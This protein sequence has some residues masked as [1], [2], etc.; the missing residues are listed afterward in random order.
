MNPLWELLEATCE[1]QPEAC[2]IREGGASRWTYAEARRRAL[3]LA[4]RLGE[5]GAVRD[6]RIALLA[7]NRAEVLVASFAAARLGA[8]LVP[9][10]PRLAGPELAAILELAECQVLLAD[11]AHLAA[12][13]ALADPSP[14]PS[15]GRAVL[16]L[17][18]ECGKGPADEPPP[19]GDLPLDAPAQ[20][21]FTS[22]TTGQPKGV[23]LTHGNIRSH[24]LAA[25]EALGLTASDTWGHFAPM[26]HLADAWATFAVTA[27]G[28]AHA[29]LPR[30]ETSACLELCSREGVTLTNLVPTMLQRVL[31]AVED[32]AAP[33][34]SLRLCLSGGAPIA[35]AVV[36]RI[37]TNLGCAYRQTYGLTETSP[38]LTLSGL[39]AEE[40]RLPL[41]QRAL[42][43]ARTGSP[44]PTVELRVVDERDQPV[45]TDD[46]TVGEIVVRGPTVSPGYW[47][48]S[49]ATA[50]S[51][52]DGWF[53][54]GD[55]ATV[56]A[57]GSVLIVDRLKDLILSGG[58]NVYSIEVEAVLLAHAGV[59][60]C[61]V[62]ALPHPDLGE[63]VAAAVV[64]RAGRALKRPALEEHC[65][66]RIAG[67]KLPRRLWLLAELPRTGSGKIRKAALRERAALGELGPEA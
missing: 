59:L 20:L 16:A 11:G 14:S 8:L 15:G 64:P 3:A 67:Y 29:F 32:G 6:S 46:R 26:F 27:V 51:R 13:R 40:E 44:F 65:R 52:R 57:S 50:A 42:R 61:A 28:G 56:D 18:E 45:P 63:C 5:L 4:A 23:I 47:R 9:L 22:G 10:N 43:L 30:F 2:A 31:A 54:T 1:R 35:P 66:A 62:F 12:A 58:E 55:L 7:D 24:A 41:A 39:T 49:D 53:R 36:E 25:V 38:Y 21:Y 33:P 60:E 17:E 19:A 34:Q 37:L 48:N